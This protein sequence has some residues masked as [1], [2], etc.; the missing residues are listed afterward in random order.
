MWFVVTG[1][2]SRFVYVVP[3]LGKKPMYTVYHPLV[4]L[5]V[6]YGTYLVSNFTVYIRG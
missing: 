4:T 2:G 1:R 3:V 5:I 6:T